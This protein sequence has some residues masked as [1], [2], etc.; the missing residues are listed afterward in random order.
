MSAKILEIIAGC[1]LGAI[2]GNLIAYWLANRNKNG[3][4]K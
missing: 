2:I 4:S 1:A 3:G